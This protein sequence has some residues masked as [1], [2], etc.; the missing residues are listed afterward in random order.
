MSLGELAGQV[1]AEELNVHLGR[2]PAP[3]SRATAPEVVEAALVYL[4]DVLAAR[5]WQVADQACEDPALGP[6]S[7]VAALAGPVD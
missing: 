2:L 6:G 5:G 3:R 1:G 4:R 7:A